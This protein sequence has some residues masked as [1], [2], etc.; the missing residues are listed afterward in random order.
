MADGAASEEHDRLSGHRSN[1]AVKR[2]LAPTFAFVLALLVIATQLEGAMHALTHV[3]EALGHTRDHSLLAADREA[4]VECALLAASGSAL[5]GAQASVVVAAA[6]EE[7]PQPAPATFAPAFSSYY[8][9]RAPPSL[10]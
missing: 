6:A 8:L 4:C 7:R 5:T 9:S 1:A 2:K 3:G 10:L